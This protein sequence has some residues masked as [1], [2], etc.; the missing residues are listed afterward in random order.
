MPRGGVHRHLDRPCGLRRLD[1]GAD[2]RTVRPHGSTDFL[3]FVT[4]SGRGRLRRPGSRD[5]LADPPRVAVIEPGTPHDYGTDPDA[6]HWSL[7]WAH[8]QPRQDWLPL[9]DWPAAAPGIRTIDVDPV[10]HD[11]IVRALGRAVSARHSGLPR[12]AA[13]AMNAVEEALLWCDTRNPRGTVLDTRLRSVLEHVGEHLDQPLTVAS[14]ARISGL[15]S[16]HLAHRAAAHL[17][18]SLMAHVE[19]Q[20]IELAQQLLSATDLSVAQ[21][22]RQVGFHD[23]LYFSRRFRALVEASPTEFRRSNRDLGSPRTSG[24]KGA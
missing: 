5:V 7:C 8:I 2:Y 16:S 19:R 20:R 23:P 1:G 18:T 22:A 10:L 21:I 9:L 6:G 13:F 14:L 24:T 17:G 15:S 11:R 4:L 12:A 3:L